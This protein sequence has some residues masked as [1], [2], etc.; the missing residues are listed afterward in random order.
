MYN[1]FGKMEKIMEKTNKKY[2]ILTYGCQMNVHESEKLAGILED[3]GFEPCTDA[4][5]ADIVVFNTCA[6]RESAEQKIF[7]N[8]GELKNIKLARPDMIIAIG[9]CMSQQD[10]YADEIL[11]RFPYV[12]IVFG[13]HNLADFEKL[14]KERIASGK[15]VSN[16]TEDETIA[17]RDELTI[18]RTS[19][20]NAWV[21]IMYGCN[22]FCTYCIVPYVRGREVSRPEKDIL[23]EIERLL[24]EGYKQIT[25]LGQN[26]NS[27]HGIDENG[28][29][30]SFAKLLLD[31][32]KFDYEFRLRFMTS[33]PKDLSSEVIDAIAASKHICHGIH[34]P[35][36]SGS[37]KI[38]A[39]MNRKY[40][41][42][43]YLKLVQE[44]REKIPDSEL[45]TDIIVGFP[46]ETEEDFEQTL[47]VIKQAKY[48][49]IFG[50]IYSKRKGTVAEKMDNQVDTQT[51]KDRLSRLLAVKNEIV[52]KMTSEML[53]KTFK[54]LV[55]SF[56]EETGTLFGSL[57]S[58]KTISFKG[59][60]NCIGEFL[61]VKVVQVRKSV[62]YGEIENIEETLHFKEKTFKE[63]IEVSILPKGEKN[64]KIL[65]E[66]KKTKK[67]ENDEKSKK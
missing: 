7:G 42:E 32:D 59:T 13:T 37:D 66:N 41:R 24:K 16:V 6:I 38:L 43:K 18:A 64:L 54:V 15:K 28:N 23:R 22:N 61:N 26:V 49:Q 55:E 4:T 35:V 48:M 52:N 25:L 39:S 57:D 45:T 36:Q 2:L 8:I 3:N 11:K 12:D 19:G 5:N 30:I 29:Q 47:D 1:Q 53:G 63:P 27:Y 10:K 44:I 65:R 31:I 21:N 58:G 46:G 34:L 20:V 62:I 56:D 60:K 9:G 51:K 14:L 40:T 33:H 17:L 50:F 67:S